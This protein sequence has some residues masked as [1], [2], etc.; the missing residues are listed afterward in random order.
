[1]L[2]DPTSEQLAEL[3]DKIRRLLDGV[4]MAVGEMYQ[5]IKTSPNP[6]LYIDEIRQTYDFVRDEQSYIDDKLRQMST[7]ISNVMQ[8]VIGALTSIDY[9]L[10]GNTDISS[11]L[12]Y[13][14]IL[15]L[16]TKYKQFF[17]ALIGKI[18][19][20]AAYKTGR[21]N[22]ITPYATQLGITLETR[23]Q[24]IANVA[25]ISE[26][27]RFAIDREGDGNGSALE[28]AQ[29]SESVN[30]LLTTISGIECRLMNS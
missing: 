4:R 22:E 26:E 6:S 12:Q 10:K 19:S 5:V 14:D 17:T 28:V 25:P 20:Y 3:S 23:C 18:L 13:T 24:R 8:E 9:Q 30:K 2:K 29:L 11:L 7:P 16:S 1:M 21:Y 27:F 15:R